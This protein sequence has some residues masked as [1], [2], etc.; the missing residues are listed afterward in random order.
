MQRD[1]NTGDEAHKTSVTDIRRYKGS[2]LKKNE[3]ITCWKSLTALRGWVLEDGKGGTAV[4]AKHSREKSWFFNNMSTEPLKV[5]R[6]HKIPRSHLLEKTR[7]SV[8]DSKQ[9]S[10]NSPG[11][12]VFPN[13]RSILHQYGNYKVCLNF[14]KHFSPISLLFCLVFF[15][16]ETAYFPDSSQPKI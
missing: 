9:C 5:H 6:L 2:E 10:F 7:S 12:K 1:Y 11:H 3:S 14:E 4:L 13:T 16:I 15:Y 8:S